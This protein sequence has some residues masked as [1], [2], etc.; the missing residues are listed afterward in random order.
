[1][2]LQI[3]SPTVIEICRTAAAAALRPD[4]LLTISEFT[5]KRHV[6][7]ILQKLE[8]PSR[9]A[10]ATF[11]RTAFGVEETAVAAAPVG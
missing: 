1:M 8:L 11:H 9:K 10:A 3:A 6:Q 7:N 5:V 2:E 4:P